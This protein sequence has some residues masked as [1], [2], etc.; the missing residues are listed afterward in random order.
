MRIDKFI[1]KFFD[2]IQKGTQERFIKQAK[3]NNTQK[4][5]KLR[6]DAV[7]NLIKLLEEDLKKL[8]EDERNN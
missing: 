4:M 6:M 8:D 1:N 5:P 7:E 3:K 2:G